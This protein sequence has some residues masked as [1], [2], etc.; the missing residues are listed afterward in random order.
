MGEEYL[1]RARSDRV[2]R[3]ALPAARARPPVQPLLLDQRGRPRA[4][5]RRADRAHQLRRA[6]ALRRP[7]LPLRR[8]L[9]AARA[10]AARARRGRAAR[11][12]RG[13]PAR[14]QPGVRACL[15]EARV[16]ARRAGRAADRD[17][18]LRATA[19]RRCARRPPA[20]CSPTRPRSIPRTAARTTPCGSASRRP[21]CW[22]SLR[23][24][25]I[26][27]AADERTGVAD[28][29]VE[30]IR[31]RGHEPL[32]HGALSESERDDWAWAS[33]AAARDVA[34]GRA[35]Q[36]IVCCWT[37]T[38]ASIAANKVAGRARGAVRRRRD[39]RRRAAL[40][41]RERA[42][43]LAPHDVRRR[44]SRRS[45]TPGSRA[46]RRRRTTT[47]RTSRTSTSWRAERRAGALRAPRRGGPER[48]GTAGIVRRRV[49]GAVAEA[50]D[51]A[52]CSL[53]T[54]VFDIGVRPRRNIARRRYARSGG[55]SADRRRPA[56]ALASM[57][58]VRRVRQPL[59]RKPDVGTRMTAPP[60]GYTRAM[61]E[62]RVSA[63]I[64]P[65]HA[66]WPAMRRAWVEAEELGVDCL[67]NWDHFFPLG[68]RTRTATHFEALTVL[69]AMAEVTERVELG[70]LVICNSYRNPDY[71]ADA[72]RTLDHISGGRA[73]LGIGAGW[74]QRDYDEYGYEFGD[75]RATGSTALEQALPRIERRLGAAQ[76]AAAARAHP[77]PDRRRRRQAHA[78]AR[79]APRGHLARVRHASTCSAR[80]RRSS[81]STAPPRAA[82]RRRSSARGRSA[83][84][85]ATT[86]T[87]CARRGVT[88]LID[89]HQRQHVGLR[90]RPAARARR[91]ARR[92]QRLISASTSSRFAS[93]CA[94]ETRLSRHSRSSGSVFDGRTLK[95]QSS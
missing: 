35:E 56:R 68:G 54:S 20:S 21:R 83:R 37:G 46:R 16:A 4:P 80:S 88:H 67:F 43:A 7:P 87:R 78:Q 74:F 86:R 63:Q 85:W 13:R 42:R 93:M 47:A 39:R 71:L 76:P 9:P 82:T 70:S 84:A 57:Q 61:A 44:C 36:G 3:R 6:R 17:R 45:S 91:V 24:M 12:L 27:I 60:S 30:E 23:F 22:S 62:I 79:R 29:V 52:R 5:V 50:D 19:S 59:P 92:G 38:G 95:C 49:R 72:H 73:I 81:T 2:L 28:A 94:R 41:R 1:G 8:Q 55:A 77:D 14:G 18:R 90:P 53:R 34:E 89:G 26:A 10:R 40:E 32:L 75:G 51:G 25:R 11:P 64:Q 48:R 58:A 15:G 66:D 69:G 65:Q 33:E 31:R